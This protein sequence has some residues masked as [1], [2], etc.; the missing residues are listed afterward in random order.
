MELYRKKLMYIVTGW[1]R[2]EDENVLAKV[3]KQR[4]FR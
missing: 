4:N 2:V 3:Y 1:V